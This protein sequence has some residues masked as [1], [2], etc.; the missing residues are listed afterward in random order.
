MIDSGEGWLGKLTGTAAHKHA[1]GKSANNPAQFYDL[2]SLTKIIVTNSLLLELMKDTTLSLDQFREEKIRAYL[3]LAPKEL[4]DIEIGA[5][6]NHCANFESHFYLDPLKSRSPYNGARPA[7]WTYILEE[8]AKKLNASQEDCVYSDLDY[9]VL[10]A[11]LESYYKQD[12]RDLWQNYKKKHSLPAND[13]VYGPVKE[14][15]I[16]TESRHPAGVVNDDNACFMQGIAPHAGLFGSAE[17]LWAW[18]LHMQDLHDKDE[19]LRDY[20]SPRGTNRFWCGWD[21]PTGDK[22]QAGEGASKEHVIGH[23]GYTGTALWWDP[24]L[25]VGGLLL[26]NRV[27]P[28]HTEESRKEIQILRSKFFSVLWQHNRDEVWKLFLQENSKA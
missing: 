26:T 13:L 12:L 14:F 18:M 15:V 22:S 27:H 23:L 1:W 9:W 20:F 16:P 25:K 4:K 28:S 11:I 6:W 21:R 10:G 3:P 7:M 8:S 24:S 2:A 19:E 5:V 17:A